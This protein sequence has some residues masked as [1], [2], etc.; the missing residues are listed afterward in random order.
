MTDYAD[1]ETDDYGNPKDGS[2]LINCCF[3]DC[4]CDGSRLCMAENGAS[5][6]CCR[7]NVEGM[8]RRSDKEAIRARLDLYG[9]ILLEKKGEK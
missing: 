7:Q 1:D 6:R 4:G 8:Y 3:P 2:R 5:D 9:S